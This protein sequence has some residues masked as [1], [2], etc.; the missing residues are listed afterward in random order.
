MGGTGLTDGF[1]VVVVVV[2]VIVGGADERVGAI[3]CGGD[4]LTPLDTAAAL[5]GSITPP[6]PSW[7]GDTDECV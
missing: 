1:V 4:K 6:P 3:R 2:V 7:V 5:S